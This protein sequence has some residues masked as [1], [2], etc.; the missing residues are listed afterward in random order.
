MQRNMRTL[1]LRQLNVRT[2]FDLEKALDNPALQKRLLCCAGRGSIAERDCS[3]PIRRLQ[4]QT[5]PTR[6][7]WQQR[8]GA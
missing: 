7:A 1:R 4:Q 6:D 5:A 8:V 3:N 2:I